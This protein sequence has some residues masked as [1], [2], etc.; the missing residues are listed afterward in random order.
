VAETAES[1]DGDEVAGS[2]AA[3]TAVRAAGIRARALNGTMT[4][5]AKPPG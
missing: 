5:S 3:S 1:D 2:G 4:A